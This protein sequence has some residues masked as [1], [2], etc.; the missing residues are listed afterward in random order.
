MADQIK[1]DSHSRTEYCNTI[2]EKN[3]M[4]KVRIKGGDEMAANARR[5]RTV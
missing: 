3:L 4:E 1:P 5:P 2:V